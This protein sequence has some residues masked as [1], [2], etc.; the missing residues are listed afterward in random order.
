MT[1]WGAW[2]KPPRTLLLILSLVTLVSVSALGWFGWKLLDQER[3]VEAQR[4]QERLEQT[5]DRLAATLRGT[6][7]EAGERLGASAANAP[8]DGLLLTLQANTLTANPP[9]RLLYYPSPR[10]NRRPLPRSSPRPNRSNS[11]RPNHKRRLMNTGNSQTP[12]T[13]PSGPARS[14]A[15]AASCEGREEIERA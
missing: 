11:S 13:Q 5:A 12:G 4:V 3:M 15:W 10:P 1:A 2:L 6:L 7:A 14:F 8:D 9:N